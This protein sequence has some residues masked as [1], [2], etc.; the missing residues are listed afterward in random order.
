M[1]TITSTST[2]TPTIIPAIIEPSERHLRASICCKCLLL[3][4]PSTSTLE[5]I[6]SVEAMFFIHPDCKATLDDTSDDAVEQLYADSC[7]ELC[8]MVRETEGVV[9][10]LIRAGRQR[11]VHRTPGELP[12]MEELTDVCDGSDLDSATETET[13]TESEMAS[14]DDESS[15]SGESE[16]FDLDDDVGTEKSLAG[17][18]NGAEDELVGRM[19]EI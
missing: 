16:Y 18:A 12:D 15:S 6:D 5:H 1:A 11:V 19:D 9:M 7:Y 2:S 3:E 17:Q 4:P 13:E 10:K 14:D 8:K